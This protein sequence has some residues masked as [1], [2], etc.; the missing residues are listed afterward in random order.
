[1]PLRRRMAVATALAVGV[2]VVLVAAVAY[3]VVRGE[4]RGQVDDQLAEQAQLVQRVGRV[5]ARGIGSAG[6]RRPAASATSRRRRR[7]AAAARPTSSSCPR[8]ASTRS[9]SAPAAR[10]RSATGRARWP[11]ANAGEFLSDDDVDGD[12]V[13]VLTVPLRGGGAIQFAR[14]LESTDAVLARLRWVLL[15]LVRGRDR[16]RRAARP[17]DRAPPRRAGHAR[18]RGGAAHRA[19]RGPRAPD[20]GHEPGRGRRAGRALQRDARHARGLDRRPAPA[21]RRRLARAAHAG[22]L[23]AHEHRGAG[24]ERARPGRARAGDRRRAGAGRGAERAG[25]RPDRARPR[26]RGQRRCSRTCGSTPWRARRSSAPAGTRRACGSPPR[27]SPPSSRASP[28]ASP[29]RSTTCSTT[30]PATATHVEIRTGPEGI[31][32]RD[33]GPGIEPADLPHIFD[34]FYRGAATRGRPGTGLG[35]AIVKQVAEQHG[36]SVAASN[37]VDGGAEFSLHLPTSNH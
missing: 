20:R 2:A 10:W 31:S 29:A 12:H 5:A 16:A 15:A 17:P 18:D 30:P 1:M 36:G 8:A 4:L 35:L 23:A 27:S 37:A 7:S 32:V 13:R 25:R 6:D 9:A 19:D 33:D 24:R 21:R 14:S 11:P 28:T 26:R 3:G 22:H 34:R